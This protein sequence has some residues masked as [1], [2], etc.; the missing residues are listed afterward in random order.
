MKKLLAGLSILGLAVAVIGIG[1]GVNLVRQNQKL[2]ITPKAAPATSLSLSPATGTVY[3]NQN[4]PVTVKISSGTNSVV[5]ADI[6]VNYNP[7]VLDVVSVSPGS[8]FGAVSDIQKF[9]ENGKI[10]YSFYVSKTSAKNGEGNLV[11]IIFKAK[12]PGTSSITFDSWTAISALTESQNVLTGSTPASFTVQTDTVAPGAISDLRVTGTTLDQVSLAWTAPA[13]TGPE[14]KA[15]LYDFRYSPTP[16]SLANWASG[17]TVLTGVPKAPGSG[18]TLTV[19]GLSENT[20]YYFGIRA[21]DAS[22]NISAIS[23]VISGVTLQRP[24]LSF[25]IKFQGISSQKADRKVKV[26]LKQGDVVKYTVSDVNTV[27]NASGVYSGT[28][29]NLAVGTYDVYIKGPAHLKEKFASVTLN[30]GPNSLDWSGTVMKAGDLSGDN[31][32]SIV[33]IGT[34]TDAYYPKNIPGSLADFN[35]DGSVNTVDIGM[36]LDNYGQGVVETP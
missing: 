32:V 35:L 6:V 4:V 10:T 11:E 30:S 24:S 23:N 21:Q 7:A 3:V 12:A 25:K 18:E 29:P 36:L 17:T 13:D 2:S 33:D 19:S 22:G 16:L 1:I 34:L 26:I 27:A 14:G 28:L 5:G 8:F 9:W 20:T 15:V 31:F